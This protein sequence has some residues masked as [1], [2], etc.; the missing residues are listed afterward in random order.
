MRKTSFFDRWEDALLKSDQ[1]VH[2]K[3]QEIANT[4]NAFAKMDH[5]PL[6][7]N[8]AD[9]EARVMDVLRD[10]KAQGIANTAWIRCS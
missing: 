10:M 4:L 7:K 9:M 2:M 1:L 3:A 5:K 6:P 8:L